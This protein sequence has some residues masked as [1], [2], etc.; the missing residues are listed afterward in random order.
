[1]E[2][3]FTTADGLFRAIALTKPGFESVLAIRGTEMNFA[4]WRENAHEL[5]AGG[6]EF[7]T[8]W[9]TSNGIKQWLMDHP[10]ASITG[11]SQGGAQAQMLAYEAARNSIKLG[12]LVTFNSPGINANPTSL[13]GILDK[14]GVTHF[15]SA[16]DIVSQVGVQFVPGNVKYYDFDYTGLNILLPLSAHTNHWAQNELYSAEFLRNKSIYDFN[17]ITTSINNPDIA[18]LSGRDFSYLTTYFDEE[19]TDFKTAIVSFL[20]GAAPLALLAGL[21]PQ[22]VSQILSNREQS[23]LAR[24]DDLPLLIDLLSDIKTVFSEIIDLGYTVTEESLEYLGSIINL[25]SNITSSS[26]LEVLR[27]S[28]SVL[29]NAFDLGYKTLS[30]VAQFAVAVFQ[31]AGDFTNINLTDIKDYVEWN[32]SLLVKLGNFIRDTAKD[33]LIKSLGVSKDFAIT[34]LD[35]FSPDTPIPVVMGN[36]A[37]STPAVIVD[38]QMGDSAMTSASGNSIFIVDDGNETIS[39][40]GGNNLIMGTPSA[41]DGTKVNNFKPSDVLFFFG[42]NLQQ[43]DLSAVKG[44]AI[45]TLDTDGD[46]QGDSVVTLIGDFRLE[47]FVVEASSSGSYIRYLGNAVPV[48]ENDDITVLPQGFVTDED[49]PFTTANV[50]TNDADGEGDALNITALDT[51]GLLGLVTDNGDGTF[52]YDP[53]GAF[54]GLNAGETATDSFGYT[55]SD[56]NGGSD[57]ATVTITINGV[58]HTLVANDDSGSVNEDSSVTFSFAQL[59]ANDVNVDVINQTIAAIDITGTV[60]SVLIDHANRTITY[61]ADADSFDLLANGATVLDS[62]KYV[63]QGDS[64]EIS[65]TVAINVTGVNDG[66]SLFGTVRRDTLNGTSGED[67]IKGKDGNDSI[68]GGDGADRLWGDK[69]ND[70]LNGGNS[71]DQLWGGDGNDRLEGGTGNDWLSGEKGNDLLIGGAG[72][73]IFAFAKAG[74]K[75]IIADFA[76]DV[77]KIQIAK[78]TGVTQ[79]SQLKIT[80]ETDSDSDDDVYTTIELGHHGNKI[81]LVGVSLGQLDATDFI[82]QI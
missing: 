40:N 79:F 57:T 25:M 31:F 76:D 37:N 16:G 38:G 10:N 63:L 5:G 65:A 15:I 29:M 69:G 1:M 4:D 42:A 51:T 44:S 32:A 74:G 11:H 73:D 55:V 81:H 2:K 56:G 24:T 49:S 7:E 36:N 72:S 61:K 6:R 48:A 52:N 3:E 77:D 8:A 45:L 33:V 47:S 28:G 34:L 30:E 71:I 80:S 17:V 67:L 46:G 41:M 54:D 22:R 66:K 75:D 70:K 13:A 62:F 35:R 60:G 39:S 59:F 20:A 78:D 53:N 12:Q 14:T 19:Y 18:A 50:L 9:N 26:P 68:N 27:L 43:N 21:G 82:F 64:G 23:E 58:S